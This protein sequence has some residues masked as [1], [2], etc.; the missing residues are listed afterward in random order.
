MSQNLGN[1]RIL[2]L[3]SFFLSSSSDNDPGVSLIDKFLKKKTPGGAKDDEVRYFHS[4]SIVFEAFF[5]LA[6]YTGV[7]FKVLD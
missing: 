3:I 5:E 6:I 2:I 1:N 4:T 7:S